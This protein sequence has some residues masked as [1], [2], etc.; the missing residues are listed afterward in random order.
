MKLKIE[1]GKLISFFVRVKGPKGVRELRAV[2][3]TGSQRCAISPVDAR[4]LG[5]DCFFDPLANKGEGEL[6][7]MQSGIMEVGPLVIEE[8]NV[9]DLRVANIEALAYELP[10]MSGV[11]MVLGLNFIENLRTSINFDEGYTIIEHMKTED[12]ENVENMEITKV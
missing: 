5:Y 9:A 2:L 6:A 8:I 10:K 3:D 7:L 12:V 4:D 1:K 11:N